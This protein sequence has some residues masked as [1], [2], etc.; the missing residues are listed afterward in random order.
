[1]CVFVSFRSGGYSGG[2]PEEGL[3]RE[4][5][6]FSLGPL[7]G[8]LSVWAQF[9]KYPAQSSTLVK[10]ARSGF[11]RIPSLGSPTQ[12]NRRTKSV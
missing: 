7:S 5:G 1:M 10:R 2:Q 4:P 3:G 9:S 8:P 11:Q 12:Q 6:G